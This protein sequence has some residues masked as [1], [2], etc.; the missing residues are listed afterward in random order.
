MAPKKPEV[1]KPKSKSEPPRTSPSRVAAQGARGS[2]RLQNLAARP[3]V[4]FDDTMDEQ[5]VD[6]SGVFRV[7]TAITKDQIGHEDDNNP[8]FA[9]DSLV[10]AAQRDGFREEG[11]TLDEEVVVDAEVTSAAKRQR[12]ATLAARAARQAPRRR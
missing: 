8:R 2:Q 9:S 7:T 6:N 1:A 5:L 10:M 12:L 11:P 3:S 4:S